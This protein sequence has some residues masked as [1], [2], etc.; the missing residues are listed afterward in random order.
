L[1]P[2]RRSVDDIASLQVVATL[3]RDRE[4]SQEILIRQD[5]ADARFSLLARG[6]CV[7]DLLVAVGYPQALLWELADELAP[8]VDVQ[9][10]YVEMPGVERAYTPS[11]SVRQPLVHVVDA[12]EEKEVDESAREDSECESVPRQQRE[13]KSG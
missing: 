12:V 6:V 4:D 1:G 5:L 10:F 9:V 2:R 7:K 3:G 13:W 11:S 8:R